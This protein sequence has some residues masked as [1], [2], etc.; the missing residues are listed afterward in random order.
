MSTSSVELSPN[1]IELSEFTD[2]KERYNTQFHLF[3]KI[4]AVHWID[5]FAMF[6]DKA[7]HLICLM[8]SA[9]PQS[10]KV[11]NPVFHRWSWAYQFREHSVL[12]LSDPALYSA[13]LSAAWFISASETD[14]IKEMATFIGG[15]AEHLNIPER[16]IIFYGSSMG[17]YGALMA[18]A[19]IDGAMAIAEVPQ[20]DL[21]KY[22]IRSSISRIEGA[23][24]AETRLETFSKKYPERVSVADRFIHENRVPSFR[25]ITNTADGAY[26]E[27]L[28]FYEDL[29]DLRESVSSVGVASLTT[30]DISI[31]HKPLPSAYG[32][33]FIKAAIQE[34]WSAKK[35]EHVRPSDSNDRACELDLTL[36]NDYKGLLDAANK[37]AAGLKYIRSDEEKVAYEQAKEWLYMAG[38]LNQAA[39]WPYLKICQMV[40]LWT[41][42]FNVEILNA[43]LTAFQRRQ[44][45]EAFIYSCRGYLYNLKPLEAA[46][47]IAEIKSKTVDA[48]TANVGKIFEAIIAYEC[49]DY[50]GYQRNIADFLKSKQPDFN[51]YISIPVSTVYIGGSY[52]HED[53]SP[54]DVS[55]IGKKLAI[56]PIEMAKEE[57]YI[58]SASCD[59]KYFRKYAEFLVRSFTRTCADEAVLH[60]SLVNGDPSEIQCKLDEWG[61]KNVFFAMQD[62]RSD[63][64]IGPI[65]SLL[66][67]CHTYQLLIKFNRPVFVVDLDTVI[68]KKL[69]GIIEEF[70]GADICSRILGFGVAPWEKYTG[71][72]ALFNPT[73]IGIF[74]AKNIAYVSNGICRD[75]E[76]QWWIDQNC[77]EAGIRAAYQAGYPINIQNVYKNRDAYC[78]MPVGS[79]DAK[80]FNLEKALRDLLE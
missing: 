27:H 16:N 48:Q 20:I 19:C 37:I 73:P 64:N 35:T 68:K 5:C 15:L 18:A 31:G 78:V 74:S 28:T 39:D 26:S 9:Q 62:L 1:R 76:K 38:K 53:F 44:S 45:L 52:A 12:S 41:N 17:G 60:L 79:D 56:A 11:L 6:R 25:I 43:A 40:K 63:A 23:I 33:S 57:R 46:S 10:G 71:G 65:A 50:A 30:T 51:P 47:A 29:K 70:A 22:P 3:K 4:D 21:S 2:I 36:N 72:F 69:S 67:F 8:P 7:Q 66:R 14:L 59:E 61:A 34:G 24:L 75:D 80:K 55:L 77:F 58:I 54:G 42:S 49:G 13:D 32:I